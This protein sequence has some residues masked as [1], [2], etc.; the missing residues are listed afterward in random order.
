MDNYED[1]STLGCMAWVVSFLIMFFLFAL[2]GN[3]LISAFVWM[4][5]H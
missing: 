2:F 3:Y 1:E 4:L 5:W